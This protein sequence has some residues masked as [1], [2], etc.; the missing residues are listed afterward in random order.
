MPR[1]PRIDQGPLERC[2]PSACRLLAQRTD[3]QIDWLRV[4]RRA[5]P[6]ANAGGSVWTGCG[7]VWNFSPRAPPATVQTDPAALKRNS[8]AQPRTADRFLPAMSAAPL[9]VAS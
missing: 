1:S 9:R 2:G 4:A 5:A 8:R 3:K 6:V 7:E